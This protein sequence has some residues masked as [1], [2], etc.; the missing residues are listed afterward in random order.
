MLERFKTRALSHSQLASFEYDRED[1]YDNYILGI[2]KPPTPEMRI[3]TVVGDA[4]GTPDSPIPE[5]QP[6]GVKEYPLQALWEDIPLIGYADHFC[7]DTLVLHE[8]KTSPNKK[9]WTQG[10]ADKHDQLTMYAFMLQLSQDIDPESVTMYLNFIPVCLTGVSL[11]V[12]GGYRQFETKRT[13]E[14]IERYKVYIMDTV[15]KMAEYAEIRD[16][17]STTTRR[18]PAFN[19]V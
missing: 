8:N 10:K 9:R 15:E 18:P 6:P 7:P 13:Q 1:W 12:C 2:R 4:I 14:D 3:G 11:N 19:G 16:R 5:L 17:L